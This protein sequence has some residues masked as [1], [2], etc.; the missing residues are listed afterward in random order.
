MIYGKIAITEW[1]L[2]DVFF[3]WESTDEQY[4]ASKPLAYTQ[5]NKIPA[6]NNIR[7]QQLLRDRRHVNMLLDLAG[8]RTPEQMYYNRQ[9][10]T[11]SKE[12]VNEIIQQVQSNTTLPLKFRNE[13]LQKTRA[14]LQMCDTKGNC[15]S[16]ELCNTPEE[17]AVLRI[18]SR[19]LKKPFVEKPVD[20]DDH[21]IRIYHED[22]SC[23]ELQRKVGN[24]CATVIVECMH[25][26][27]NESYIYEEYVGAFKQQFSKLRPPAP[28]DLKIY[29][30]GR[31]KRLAQARK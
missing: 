27:N 8:I 6:I 11:L 16:N 30:L 12:L 24:R 14:E 15:K 5:R 13:I 18:G 26:R 19:T 23:T 31:D 1:P 20:A 2:V 28:V 4:N 29:T 10:A 7:L 9:D 21:S 25:P 22:G 3:S 17:C